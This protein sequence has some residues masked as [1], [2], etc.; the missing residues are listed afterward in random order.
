MESDVAHRRHRRAARL[1][2]PTF[3]FDKPDARE[4]DRVVEYRTHQ[5]NLARRQSADGPD[6]H[7]EEP[8]A[9]K[10]ST[11]PLDCFAPLAKTRRTTCRPQTASLRQP[12]KQ[13]GG[14]PT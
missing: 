14:S 3:A 11:A 2:R 9:T 6:R 8:K 10:Q 4:V 12:Q 7:C 13:N 5:L 1:K